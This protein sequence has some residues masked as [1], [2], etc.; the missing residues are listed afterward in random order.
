[1]RLHCRDFSSQ[2]GEY[3][4]TEKSLILPSAA[5]GAIEQR[6]LAFNREQPD[7]PPDV[8]DLA[9]CDAVEF[10]PLVCV[11]PSRRAGTLHR[12]TIERPLVLAGMSCVVDEAFEYRDAL[13]Q[14][15][16]RIGRP[17]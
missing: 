6:V 8:G 1:M 5:G 17:S 2:L 16:A 12:T 11:R 9:C 10:P 7:H 13:A 4:M 15:P 3:V 14:E